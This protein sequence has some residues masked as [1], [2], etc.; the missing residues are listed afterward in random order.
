MKLS[1]LKCRKAAAPQRPIKLTDGGGLY[2]HVYPNGRK[3]WRLAYRLDGKQRVLQLGA[4]P[5]VT[6]IK[7]RLQRE[8]ARAQLADGKDPSG[9]V[10]EAA[11]APD[12]EEPSTFAA[13]A[14]LHVQRLA[15]AGRAEPTLKKARWILED[16]AAELRPFPIADIKPRD[17][18]RVLR[19][20][21]A[22]GNRETARRMRGVLSAV[23]RLAILEDACDSDPTA[24][25]KGALL[26][27][28]VRHH[29]ALI[30][31]RQFGGLLRAIDGYD[32]HRVVRLG[33]QLLALTFPRPGELRLTE[34]SEVRLDEALWV[35]PAARTKMRREHRIP[36]SRQALERF[37]ELGKITGRGRL[38]FPSIRTPAK[39]LSD[40]A[41]NA[42][43][44]AMGIDGAAH[45]SHGFRSS[46]ASILNEHSTFAPDVIERALAH[47]EP[48]KIR[49]AYNRADYWAERVRMMQWWAD[50]CDRI[51]SVSA[52]SADA[53]LTQRVASP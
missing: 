26:A 33:L 13:F 8:V 47:G 20:V 23:F 39:P 2:L 16:L 38:C 34:W 37:E 3:F 51:K 42:S 32:G 35:V 12:L 52:P 18:L 24:S 6:L 14:D 36:L 45:V 46:A 43:L 7:A 11:A 22:K 19:V 10:S 29:S 40:G 5:E 17:V 27:P 41:L 53:D 48:D 28:K 49:R 31:P 21:E 9:R 15:L 44:R 25:L 1:D 4:Y 30:E 50:Y